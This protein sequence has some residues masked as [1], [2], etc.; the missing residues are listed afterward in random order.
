MKIICDSMLGKLAKKLRI[1]GFDTAYQSSLKQEDIL[2]SARKENRIILTR[3]ANFSAKNEHPSVLFIND[4][5]P[6]KQIKKVLSHFK[7]KRDMAAPFSL[8]ICCNTTL[9]LIEKS[10]AEGKVADYVFNTTDSFSR[11]PSCKK[12]YWCG[13]HHVN[14]I[15]WINNIFD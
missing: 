15:K 8:C 12:I 2:S 1:L 11:C 9:Q 10:E 3:K 6:N 4:N 5:D 7:I 13:T 14:M